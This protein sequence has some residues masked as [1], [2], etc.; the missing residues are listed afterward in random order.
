MHRLVTN[1]LIHGVPYFVLVYWWQVRRGKRGRQYNWPT[2]IIRF[3]ATLWLLAFLEEMLWDHAAW[4][5]RTWLFGSGWQLDGLRAFIVPLLALPQWTH[6][7]L[8]GFIW[9]RRTNPDVASFAD[10]KQ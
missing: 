8:D 10:G 4:H 1:V 3:L 6:Y 2:R 9:R 7:V 5:E